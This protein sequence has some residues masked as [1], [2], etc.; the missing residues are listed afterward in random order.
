MAL[1]N[2][3]PRILIAFVLSVIVAR[4]AA[5]QQRPNVVVILADDM[6]YSDLGCY[7][8]EIHTPNIDRLASEGIHF[9]QFYNMARCCPTRASLLTGLYP[10]QAGIG[11]M[12]QALDHKPAY[13]GELNDHCATIAELLRDAGYHT[14]MVG[15]WHLCHVNIATLPRDQA[16]A[17]LAFESEAPISPDK[18][19]WPC[20]RGF[21]EH[22]G[23]M[24]GVEDYYDPYGLVHNEQTIKPDR[25]DF[26]YTDFITDRA[27]GLIDGYATNRD[28]PFFLYVAYTA[29][30][31]PMQARG[32]DVARYAETYAVGWDKIREARFERMVRMG[33]AKEQWTLSPRAFNPALNDGA[34]AVGPWDDAPAKEWQARRMAV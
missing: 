21:E 15:K 22:W 20:N 13:Q 25:P 5:A 14:G 12:N 31:W 30:H 7:G 4:A 11:A 28:K 23:T 10:H 18:K 8:G 29:P 16:K 17:A 24:P 1:L 6:G 33:L 27:V 34:S 3:L 19:N 2:R 26:Y 32:E 9:A